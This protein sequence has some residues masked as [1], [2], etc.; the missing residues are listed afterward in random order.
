M[1]ARR[2]ALTHKAALRA[3]TRPLRIKATPEIRLS[4]RAA[5]CLTVPLVVG[6]VIN[7]RFYSIVFAIGALWA[8]SQDGLDDWH[9]R[10]RRLLWVS[11]AG[12]VGVALGATFV[13]DHRAAWALVLL[14][15]GVALIAGYVE[16]SNRATAGAYLLIGTILGG[17]L[18]F[19][20]KVWQ[21]ALAVALGSFWL[22]V[23][24]WLMY[25]RNH[26]S[27]QR[28]ALAR[29]FNDLATVADAVG[30]AQFYAVRDRAVSNL[31]RA[32]DVIGSQALNVDDPE[33]VALRQ[34]LVVA[35]QVGEVISYL[36]GKHL[37]VDPLMSSGLREVASILNTS[38]AR[39]A[40][41]ELENFPHRF[42][43]PRGLDPVV[44]SALT[45]RDVKDL[46]TTAL[47]PL[48]RISRRSTLS[49]AERLRFALLLAVAIAGATA[50]SVALNDPHGFW[51]PLSVAFILRPDVGPVI[52]RALARTVGTAVGVGIAAIVA[53][54]GNAILVLIVLSC[55]M[56]AVQPWASR[57]SHTL[58]VIAFTPIVFVFL[59][60]LG[61]DKGLFGARIID[62]ALAAGIVLL[63]DVFGWT[64]APSM[65]PA[66][67][68]DAA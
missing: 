50:I 1:F 9:V 2:G 57:R 22:Y 53:L 17:G 62:T 25:R 41:V 56:A 7:Q 54:T 60:I 5:F 29:A 64:T 51:L 16:A 38:N 23:V 44:L 55:V 24:S 4:L 67:H 15:G 36:E 43:S 3:M 66:A 32:H 12:G 30:T 46:D 68:L 65:R 45:P 33:R 31:D 11:V 20:G 28:L 47:R 27:T 6:L 34:C 49:G 37:S 26:L 18:V 52:T 40:V 63:L 35:L 61:S 39:S 48:M 10:G 8:I 19:T 14:F 42:A 21:S 59:G 58:A 13:N